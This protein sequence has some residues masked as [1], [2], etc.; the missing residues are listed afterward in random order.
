MKIRVI[1]AKILSPTYYERVMG[2]QRKL[3][4]IDRP[5]EEKKLP[6]VLSMQELTSILKATENLKHRAILTVIY[7]A[8]LRIGEVVKLKITDIDSE[9]M[10]I[11]ICQSKGRKD[12]YT[13]L[14]PKTLTMLRDYFK[15]YK[16]KTHLFE[17]KN[18]E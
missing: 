14:S 6:I 18:G 4:F 10:Q 12:R 1:S 9:R 7:S 16:P 5:L 17:G 11:R 2:G 8:G 13:L 3:Y 15:V